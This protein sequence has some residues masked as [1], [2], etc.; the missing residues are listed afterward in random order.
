[1]TEI[2]CHRGYSGKYPENTMLAFTE[3]TK[4][5]MEAL[6]SNSKIFTKVNVPKPLFLLAKNSQTFI[7]FCVTLVVFFLFVAL[8]RATSVGFETRGE[9]R[10]SK[11]NKEEK[12]CKQKHPNGYA[13]AR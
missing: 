9:K 12:I 7:S 1:M 13:A 6:I 3:A 11:P 2:Y 4:T 8:F 10:V 5:G